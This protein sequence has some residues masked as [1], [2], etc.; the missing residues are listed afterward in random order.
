MVFL[1]AVAAV[2]LVAMRPPRVPVWAWPVAGSAVLVLLRSEPLQGALGA[3]ESQWNVLL[4]ILG[5]MGMSIAAE[6]SGV[7]TWLTDLL[8]VRAGGSRRRLFAWLYSACTATTLLLSNDATAIVLTPI[9]YAA[10]ARR[11]G[12]PMPYLFACAFVANA[13][14][15]GL[16]FSNPANVLILPQPRFLEYVRALGVPELCAIAINFAIFAWVFRKSLRGSYAY[17]PLGRPTARAVRTLYATGFVGVLYLAALALRFPLGPAAVA[18]ACIA[19]VAAGVPPG[20]ALARVSWRTFALLA[21]LFVLLDGVARAGFVG[22]AL[23]Q[24][25][26]AARFGP[27]AVSALTAFGAAGLS[28]ALNNLPVAVAASY[29][30][31]HDAAANVAYPAIAGVDLGPNLTTTGSLATL[32]WLSA[33]SERGVRID[34]LQ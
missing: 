19:L 11:G 28:N 4:F 6:Q 3:I 15:F 21:G 31:A 5:L 20:A 10:V 14:S 27:L 24:L 7:F 34:P 2:V 13:A 16:P 1:I 9:V 26:D 12:D 17:E 33:L 23:A 32:L 29:V 22:W 30:A 18:G 25:H 8:L